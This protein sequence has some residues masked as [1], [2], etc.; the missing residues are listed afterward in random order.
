MKGGKNKQPLGYTIIEV[1]IVLA[2]SG[3]MFLI[4]A[5]FINGKA[6]LATFKSS[7]TELATNLQANINDVVA[8]KYSDIPIYCGLDGRGKLELLNGASSQSTQGTNPSCVFI[9]KFIYFY[10]GSDNLD[11]K[12]GVMS[13]AGNTTNINLN[14]LL[15]ITSHVSPGVNSD[16]TINSQN[17]GNIY[18]KDGSITF[19]PSSFSYSIHGFGIV[20]LPS[21]QSADISSGNVNDIL[22]VSTY[23]RRSYPF[24]TAEKKVSKIINTDGLTQ[25]SGI[26]MCFTDGV[27]YAN[28]LIGQNSTGN[29]QSSLV[30]NIQELGKA[31]C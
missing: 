31:Q 20:Q 9:G 8:G 12:Y 13:I 1:M 25:A 3:V 27:S 16:L 22:V 14:T 5:T 10:K 21:S 11:D 30:V 4:A 18:L 23:L 15:P 17:P 19:G 29:A 2:I 24:S 6:E 26:S 7:I 28:L